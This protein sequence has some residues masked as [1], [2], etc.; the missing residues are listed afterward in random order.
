MNASGILCIMRCVLGIIEGVVVVYNYEYL[1]VV[2]LL[3][4]KDDVFL[5]IENEICWGFG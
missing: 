1:W 3:K 4:V 5:I 2:W